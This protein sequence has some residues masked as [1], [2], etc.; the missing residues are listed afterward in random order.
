[1][2]LLKYFSV[3]YLLLLAYTVIGIR[4]FPVDH[5]KIS[6][7]YNLIPLKKY[8]DIKSLH[9]SARVLVNIDFWGNVLLFIPFP[10]CIKM[11]FKINNKWHLLLFGC[12]MSIAIEI[13]Q[14]IFRI[15]FAD[16]NDVITNSIGTLLGLLFI[17][18]KKVS[19]EK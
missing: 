14:Y 19:N 10:F 15:G 17:V 1:M 12:I 8:S 6:L 13:S 5:Y 2:R 7:G 16:I 3:I 4:I 11:L 18:Q 9:Q